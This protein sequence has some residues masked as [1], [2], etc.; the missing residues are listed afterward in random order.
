M[1]ICGQK[2]IN[3]RIYYYTA[4][5]WNPTTL[6]KVTLAG[7]S[8]CSQEI[9]MSSLTIFILCEKKQKKNP[10][11]LDNLLG[12]LIIVKMEINGKE[13]LKK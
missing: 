8:F 3:R 7:P 11:K 1:P 9:Y 5:L 2:L 4:L 10:K 6:G 12:S 13:S